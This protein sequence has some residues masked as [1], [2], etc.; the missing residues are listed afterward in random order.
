MET[1]KGIK[2]TRYSKTPS[3]EAGLG[4]REQMRGGKKLL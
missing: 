3:I 1:E 4:G 2:N